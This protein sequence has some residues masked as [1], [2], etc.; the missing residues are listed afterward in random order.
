M[1]N[2]FPIGATDIEILDELGD[3]LRELRKRRGLSQTEAARRSGL[4]RRTVY[5]AE[6]GENPRLLTLVRLLRTY[7]RLGALESFV[8]VPDVSPIAVIEGR[9]GRGR[10]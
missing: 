9:S 8:P 2:N 10:G 1:S 6:H 3:R 5:A 4:A 7:G